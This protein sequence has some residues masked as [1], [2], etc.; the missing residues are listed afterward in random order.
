MT[1]AASPLVLS[2]QDRRLEIPGFVLTETHRPAGL[3]LPAHFH[4]HTNIA[5]TIEGSFVETVGAEPYEVKS[6]SVIFRPA[7]EKHANRYGRASAHC[8]I[9]EVKPERLTAIREVTQILDRPR[10][11]K[12]GPFADFAFRMLREFKMPDVVAPL[13]IEALVLEMLVHCTRRRPTG[14]GQAPPWLRMAKE[15]VHERFSDSLTLS[16]VARLLGVHPAHLAKMFRSHYHCTLGDYIRA[17]RLDRAAE[18]LSESQQTLSATAL[19]A[20]FYDQSH[21]ARLFKRRFGVTPGVFRAGLRTT[22]ASLPAKHKD[23]PSD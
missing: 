9:I 16:G 19:E 18:L 17:L 14:N 5:L 23:L 12:G 10:Y 4:E 22:K 8:L 13:A 21:F 3:V 7:G 2:D 6:G 20:G 11:A 15:I 1:L